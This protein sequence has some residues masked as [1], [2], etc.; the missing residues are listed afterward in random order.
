MTDQPQDRTR[1]SA[2]TRAEE[3]AEAKVTV[4]AGR[5]P[6]EAEERAAD[7]NADLGPE[8][9]AHYEEMTERGA[10]QRGEGRVP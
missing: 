1:P 4:G 7:G 2:E 6:T 8:V 10:N 9:G 5:P 3:T